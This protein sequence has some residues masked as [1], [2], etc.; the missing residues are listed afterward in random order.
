MCCECGQ[1]TLRE[2]TARACSFH[3]FVNA[4]STCSFNKL[5]LY[6]AGRVWF[7]VQSCPSR[8]VLRD[9]QGPTSHESRCGTAETRRPRIHP[10]LRISS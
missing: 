9:I 7:H 10:V 1:A 4:A 8:A 2:D 3:L 5:L 6:F